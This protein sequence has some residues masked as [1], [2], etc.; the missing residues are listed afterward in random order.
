[1][2]LY[3][4]TKFHFNTALIVLEIWAAGTFPPPLPPGSGTQKNPGSDRVKE[5]MHSG[6]VIL[7]IIAMRV[8]KHFHETNIVVIC[9]TLRRLQINKNVGTCCVKVRPVSNYTQQ[10]PTNANIVVVPCKRTQH[11]GPS[12]VACCW[13]TT[14]VASV[15]MDLKSVFK[16]INKARV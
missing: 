8:L 16:E 2:I 14:N 1:M 15:C 11:V 13:P 7:K 6:T 10:V 4:P 3:Y 9:A 5:A 12:N